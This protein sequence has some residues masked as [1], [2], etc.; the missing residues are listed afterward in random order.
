MLTE[1]LVGDRYTNDDIRFALDLENL[2]GIRPAVDAS[3]NLRHLAIMTA[4]H[5]YEKNITENPYND[6]IENGILTYTAQ[7]RRGHQ[8]ITGRNR[9]ILEQYS[10]PCP[11][12][13]FANE[14]RQV[15]TFLGLLELLRHYQEQ[16]IDSRNSLRLVWVFEFRIHSE[17]AVVPVALARE[18]TA[19]FLSDRESRLPEEREVV[20]PES[21]GATAERTMS[22]ETEQLRS[23]LFQINPYTFET[24]VKDVVELRGFERVSVTRASQDGGID[25]N[26]YVSE[27]NY[28][29]SRTHVQFQVKRWR[30]S[31]GSVDINGFRGA[32]S[33]TAKGVFITTSH[34]TRAAV[35]EAEHPTKPVISLID[36]LSFSR[37]VGE[38]A[39][40][41]EDYK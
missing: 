29:F 30:H 32:L 2:G 15:Y 37:L 13:C 7:G 39:I 25:L 31:I 14:G 41:L 21:P 22:Y 33:T 38:L 28:F 10:A 1:F 4:A 40:D 17:I 23:Q 6:R 20:L 34:F 19:A 12:Y 24:L 5:T 11:F 9:R 8:E 3:K 16:Q 27:S 26:A 36:G 18:L 35:K